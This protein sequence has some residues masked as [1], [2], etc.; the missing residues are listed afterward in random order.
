MLTKVSKLPFFV[1]ASIFIIGLFALFAILYI[2]RSIIIPVVFATILAIVLHPVVNFFVK[3]KINRI[4]AIGLALLLT[5]LFIAGLGLLLF[6]QA[7]RFSDS[8]PQLVEKF[9]LMINS[10]ITW[11]AGYFDINPLR[12]HEWIAKAKV[13]IIDFTSSAIGPT[14]MSVGGTLIAI[15]LIPV[16][17]FMILFYEPLL[18]DFIRKVFA[19]SNHVQVNEIISQ[20]KKVIQRYLVGLAIEFVIITLLYSATLFLLGVDYAIMIGIICGLINVIPYIGGFVGIALPMMIALATKDSAWYSIYVLIIFYFI[21][22]LSLI[23]I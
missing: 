3:K 8:W 13:E 19:K 23:H 7:S 5:F 10:S 6:T 1:R 11:S 17:I 14:L 12:I 18:I 20:I 22:M 21:Q 15:F 4:I 9:T 16:Y 2:G